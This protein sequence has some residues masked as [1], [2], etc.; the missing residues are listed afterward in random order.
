MSDVLALIVI[1]FMAGFTA[2]FSMINI[3][4]WLAECEPNTVF[5]VYSICMVAVCIMMFVNCG[6]LFKSIWRN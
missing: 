1:L 4:L 2:I 5:K 6:I 3:E